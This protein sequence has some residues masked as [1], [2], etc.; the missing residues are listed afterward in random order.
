MNHHNIVWNKFIRLTHWLVAVIIILDMFIFT[1]GADLHIWLGYI[2]TG[3]VILRLI[4][5][6]I[7]RHQAHSLSN[8]PLSASS[9]IKFFQDKIKNRDTKYLGHNPAASLVYVLIWLCVLGLT[10]TG[11]MLGLDRFFGD[12]SVEQA[13]RIINTV[14]QVTVI[15]HLL[16][17][18]L[19]SLQFKRKAWMSMLTGRK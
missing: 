17:L 12:E 5:G 14:L 9:L 19:D 18:L 3:L 16:G 6:L 10:I 1:D 8:F 13:H 11:W 2:V 4:Y 7:S 15:F